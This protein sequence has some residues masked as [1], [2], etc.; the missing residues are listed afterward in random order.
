MPK[1]R[2]EPEK[3]REPRKT[4]PTTE[5]TKTRKTTVPE[6]GPSRPYLV[7]CP[8]GSNSLG[9]LHRP[10]AQLEQLR[11]QTKLSRLAYANRRND[12]SFAC[13]VCGQPH[14]RVIVG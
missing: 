10:S 3:K 2:G 8:S 12:G 14:P 1:G 5:D 4:E 7:N 9:V 11:E 6:T 13:T